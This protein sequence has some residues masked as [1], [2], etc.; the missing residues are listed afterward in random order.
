[1]QFETIHPFLDGNGRLG[2]LLITLLLCEKGLLSEPILYLSLY[3]KKNRGLYY[4]LLQQ[5]RTYGNWEVWLEFF[6]NGVYETALQ[7]LSTSEKMNILFEQDL[8][9]INSLGRVKYSCRTVF[10]YL[11]KLP[12]LSV[13]LLT[14][15]LKMTAP[16]AR[17]S[18]NHL[19]TLGIVTE[20][21]TKKRD[22]VYVYTKYLDLLE[23][24]TEPLEK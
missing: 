12:Q 11:K 9:K 21:S 17:T 20:I 5:V 19:L 24:G 7:A 14:K 2:R 13:S 10:E 22:K 23:S 3:L 16:T 1:V 8:Q 18:L 4:D 6:L 15:E